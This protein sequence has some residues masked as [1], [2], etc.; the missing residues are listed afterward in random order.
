MGQRSSRSNPNRPRHPHRECLLSVPAETTAK[1]GSNGDYD[2]RRLFSAWPST[3]RIPTF[4]Y[5]ISFAL[6]QALDCYLNVSGHVE[7]PLCNVLFY[8]LKI[9]DRF[10]NSIAET[11]GVL[12]AQF[13]LAGS[14]ATTGKNAFGFVGGSPNFR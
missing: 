2:T 11:D 13:A 6:S 1:T 7:R 5:A 4:A 14:I 12:E 3:H 9:V 10:S 8:F